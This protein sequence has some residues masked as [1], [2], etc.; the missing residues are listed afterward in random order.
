M[1][2]AFFENIR[3]KIN[4]CGTTHGSLAANEGSNSIGLNETI[5]IVCFFHFW[6]PMQF[7]STNTVCIILERDRGQTDEKQ[8]CKVVGGVL[9]PFK[10]NKREWVV[11]QLKDEKEWTN[12]PQVRIKHLVFVQR[13]P[14]FYLSKI[15]MDILRNA[16]V[17]FAELFIVSFKL[18]VVPNCLTLCPFP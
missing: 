3:I 10:A 12:A 1:F 16:H 8:G 6:R 11:C 7:A 9:G 5:I 17:V 2:R 14:N 4:L 13:A 18:V 15:V